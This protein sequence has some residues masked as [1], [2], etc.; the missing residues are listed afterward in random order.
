MVDLGLADLAAEGERARIT[1]VQA[2]HRQLVG[3][4]V[5]IRCGDGDL[6]SASG[7]GTARW[8]RWERRVERG[9][10]PVIR[11]GR[12]I[13]QNRECRRREHHVIRAAALSDRDIGVS[14]AIFDK[15]I[16]FD[17]FTQRGGVS[18]K[19]HYFGSAVGI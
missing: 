10:K 3:L 19:G 4:D 7:C 6:A 2:R 17:R 8:L 15:P 5:A 18:C 9:R 12:A 11:Q 1:R 16:D 13:V 14:Q